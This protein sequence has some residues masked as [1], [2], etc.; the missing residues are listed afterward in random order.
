M[1]PGDHPFQPAHL[2]FRRAA[3][4]DD[5]AAAR[6]AIPNTGDRLGAAGALRVLRTVPLG[7]NQALSPTSGELVQPLAAM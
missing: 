3:L 4:R 6:A 7:G 2:R 1:V 5:S